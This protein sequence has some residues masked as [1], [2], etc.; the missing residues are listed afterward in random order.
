MNVANNVLVFPTNESKT[1]AVHVT[2]ATGPVKGELKLAAPQ[3]WEVSPPSIPI[4]LK[5]ANAEMVA[6]FSIKPPNQNSEGT[7]RAIASI[8]GRDY[9]LERV[10]LPPHF[11]SAHRRTNADATGA[12]QTCSR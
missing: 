4:D 1:V 3:G 9:S 8:D 5:A 10:P 11:L 7:L 2:A 6:T 12:S